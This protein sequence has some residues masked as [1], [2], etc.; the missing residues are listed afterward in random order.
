MLDD[1]VIFILA[2][3]T[4]QVVGLTGKYSRLSNLVGGLLM[5]TLGLILILKPAWLSFS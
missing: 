2:M 4:L 3:T 5:L 1:L